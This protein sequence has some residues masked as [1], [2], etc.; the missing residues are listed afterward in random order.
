MEQRKKNDTTINAPGHRINVCTTKDI[1][2]KYIENVVANLIIESLANMDLEETFNKYVNQNLGFENTLKNKNEKH[3]DRRNEEL[4]KLTVKLSEGNMQPHLESIL[5]E[6][7]NKIAYEIK[8]FEQKV[9]EQE[10]YINIL[11][12]LS[13]CDVITKEDLLSDRIQARSLIKG[14]IKGI[15][16][17]NKDIDI[18]L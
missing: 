13:V 4:V 5:M 17:D 6:K 2:A 8:E 12:S 11:K 9:Q 7:M 10:E 16:V 15:T 14:I 1:N 18:E 3:I